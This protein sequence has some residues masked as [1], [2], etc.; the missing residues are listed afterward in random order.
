MRQTELPSISLQVSSSFFFLVVVIEQ[1]QQQQQNL[2]CRHRTYNFN[3]YSSN[4]NK[5]TYVSQ[6][7]L[8]KIR[9]LNVF[10][11]VCLIKMECAK[12]IYLRGKF[13]AASQLHGQAYSGCSI[14][15]LHLELCLEDTLWYLRKMIH[16][17]KIS[18]LYRL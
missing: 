4:N 7:I 18:Q 14:G 12:K 3:F 5:L 2:S 15:V 11:Y 1:Q 6:P 13:K 10:R 9:L 8:R 17:Y 16:T